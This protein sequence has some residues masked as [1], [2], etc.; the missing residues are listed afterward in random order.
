MA[1]QSITLRLKVPDIPLLS[2]EQSRA[3]LYRE[4]AGAM[5]TIVETMA[6]EVRQRTPVGATGILRASINTRVTTGTSLVEAIRGEVFS[7]SQA[8]YAPYVEYGTGPH[9]APIGPLLLWARRVLG[10]ARAAYAVQR[11]IARRGTRAR[12][13]FREGFNAVLPRVPQIFQQA[14]T[15]AARLLQGGP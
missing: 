6:A 15:R 5:Q 10:H 8:P 1:E 2:P 12:H 14:M 3:V 4:A 9:W 13:M 7:S 11:A